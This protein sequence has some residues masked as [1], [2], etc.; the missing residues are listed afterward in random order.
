MER[1]GPSG[2]TR[3]GQSAVAEIPTG[4]AGGAFEARKWPLVKPPVGKLIGTALRRCRDAEVVWEER[5]DIDLAEPDYR[6]Q[7]AGWGLRVNQEGRSGWTWGSL[8]D[9][10]ENLLE[11][12]IHDAREGPKDAILF[13]HGLPFTGQSTTPDPVEPRPHLASLS[14]LVDRLRFLVPSIVPKRTITIR[15]GLRMQQMCLV[16][17]AGEQFGQRVV[18]NVNVKATDGLPLS[19]TLLASRLRESPS[20]LLMSLAWRSAH[21]EEIRSAPEGMQAVVF[22]EDATAALLRD[23]INEH[24]DAS[25]FL[26]TPDLAAPWGETWLNEE[27]TVEDNGTLPSGPGSVPFDG[28]GSARRPVALIHA[29]VVHHHLAD[30]YHAKKLGV[31][32]AGLAVREWGQ[33]PRPGY[34][35]LAMLPGKHT[36]GELARRI[37]NGI[38]LDALAPCDAPREPGEFC[39]VAQI[40]F[41]VQNGRPTHRLQPFLVRGIFTDILGKGLLGIGAERAWNLRCFTPPIA[42]AGVMCEA[43]PPE[44][45]ASEERGGDWW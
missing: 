33:P 17:R 39:R 44:V 27:V 13:S 1:Y 20:D 29:G 8:E 26:N 6:R 15:A 35:N 41:R 40:A 34:S 36:T 11:R 43:L 28:E 42:T 19:A 2:D 25:R 14:R 4:H 24:F 45:K 22:S 3:A 30:R 32:A 12:A 38:I 9:T 5:T 16:T 21:S 23:L 37:G 7:S 18:Y 10:P 31:G